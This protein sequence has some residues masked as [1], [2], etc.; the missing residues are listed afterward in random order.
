ATS[1][2]AARHCLSVIVRVH[3]SQMSRMSQIASRSSAWLSGSAVA[4]SDTAR[5]HQSHSEK[6]NLALRQRQHLPPAHGLLAFGVT[7]AGKYGV[8]ESLERIES[9]LYVNRAILRGSLIA[10]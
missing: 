10:V 9:R 8:P 1:L 4:A 2:I 3:P 5:L 7:D 6:L